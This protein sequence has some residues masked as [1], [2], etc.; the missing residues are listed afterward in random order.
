[1]GRGPE[2]RGARPRGARPRGVRPRGVRPRGVEG[3]VVPVFVLWLTVLL[4]FAIAAL[5][6]GRKSFER[7]ELQ[8][9]A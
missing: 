9:A 6:L 5:V 1:M 7:R 3:G 2:K 8:S 4:G